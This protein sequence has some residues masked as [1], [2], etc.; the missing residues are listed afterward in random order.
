MASY[1]LRLG[2]S[3]WQARAQGVVIWVVLPLSCSRKGNNDAKGSRWLCI[4][5]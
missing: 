3:N 1:K 5:R 4:S 2:S